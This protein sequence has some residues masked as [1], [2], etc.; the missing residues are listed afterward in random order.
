MIGGILGVGAIG[1][2]VMSMIDE[3]IF[4]TIVNIVSVAI[5]VTAVVIGGINAI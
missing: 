2:L 1:I 4:Q 5:L 3:P